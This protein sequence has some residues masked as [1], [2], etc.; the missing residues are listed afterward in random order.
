MILF[1]IIATIGYGLSVTAPS[2][3]KT[4]ATLN[5]SSVPDLRMYRSFWTLTVA[6]SSICFSGQMRSSFTRAESCSKVAV[7]TGFV[8]S[9]I[10]PTLK[11][12][13]LARV[14]RGCYNLVTTN[15]LSF[16]IRGNGVITVGQLAYSNWVNPPSFTGLFHPRTTIAALRL[17]GASIADGST[18]P[19]LN[20]T[21]K[22]LSKYQGK[23]GAPIRRRQNVCANWRA[24][25]RPV[26][27]RDGLPSL[28][29]PFSLSLERLVTTLTEEADLAG[30]DRSLW[31]V[32]IPEAAYPKPNL[33]RSTLL[34]GLLT[35]TDCQDEARRLR[36]G[37][38]QCLEA[39]S[40]ALLPGGRPRMGCDAE[41][42]G[43]SRFTFWKSLGVVRS[44]TRFR[45][46]LGFVESTG[47]P[48][49]FDV[50][51]SGTF[52][53]SIP[54][55]ELISGWNLACDV[56]DD[57]F[58][59]PALDQLLLAEIS[60]QELFDKLHAA[61]FEKLRVGFQATVEGHRDFPWA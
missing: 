35:Y 43:C 21:A 19:V 32:E 49:G 14:A 42:S 4:P 13:P 2:A 54:I 44:E 12:P 10:T 11:L 51:L 29:P 18:V 23:T 27:R 24:V 16:L 37:G 38:T 17:E 56:H 36:Q 31:A 34:G 50:I 59:L 46:A 58:T 8:Q 26:A 6:K 33:P 40:A 25:Y 57:G 53:P 45:P 1:R 9:R 15:S 3:C 5:A 30:V 47:R 52:L 7:M 41:Y 60:P 61:V 39:P 48:R 22:A 28:R 20:W 55:V